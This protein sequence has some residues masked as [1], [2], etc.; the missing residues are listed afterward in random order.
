MLK[1]NSV[2]VGYNAKLIDNYA[3]VD[4]SVLTNLIVVEVNSTIPLLE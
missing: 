3:V 4:K 2:A 1:T